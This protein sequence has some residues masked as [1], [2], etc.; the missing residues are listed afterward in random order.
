MILL[1][2]IQSIIA[3]HINHH[4]NMRIIRKN[5]HIFQIKDNAKLTFLR[6]FD[7]FGSKSEL[8]DKQWQNVSNLFPQINFITVYCN[9]NKEICSNFQHNSLTQFYCLLKPGETKCIEESII[10]NDKSNQEFQRKSNA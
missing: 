9:E 4:S 7:Y 8:S 10:K 2:F 6:L 5:S 1:L 3:A